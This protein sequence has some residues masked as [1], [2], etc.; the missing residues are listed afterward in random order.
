MMRID[1]YQCTRPIGYSSTLINF[2]NLVL[3]K[4]CYKIKDMIKEEEK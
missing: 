4:K 3:C 2:N 1:C